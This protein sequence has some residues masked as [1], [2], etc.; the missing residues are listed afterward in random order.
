MQPMRTLP[1]DAHPS[2]AQA[3]VR[4][5]AIAMT[6]STTSRI[7]AVATA[8][9]PPALLA[10]FVWHPYLTGR[11]PN[12]PA[13]AEAVAEDPVRWGLAHLAAGIASGVVVLAFIAVRGFLRERCDDRWSALGLPFI[14]I[15]SVLYAMLPGMEFAPVA[16]VAAGGDPEAAQR[17]LQTWFLSVL[18][19]GAVTFA[20]GVLCVAKGI[21]GR[22][23]LSPGVTRL[24]VVA[25]VVFAASRTVPLFVVQG[26]LQ[27]AAAMVALWP[28]A[29]QMWSPS[30]VRAGGTPR[31]RS[32]SIR[33]RILP[34]GDRGISSTNST[35]RTR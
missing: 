32:A 24:V 25:L 6:E 5:A 33:R 17:A 1:R 19:I 21:A 28:L 8:L 10:A 31:S 23:I 9:A 7:Q 3:G 15:G 18:L 16:A 14:V 2:S 29:A 13:I 11:L 22:S 4:G 27:A 26:Y 30:P 12:A 20:V 34:A 35:T